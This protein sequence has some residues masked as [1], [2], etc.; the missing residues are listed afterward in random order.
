MVTQRG[1]K[2]FENR[3]MDWSIE[4]NAG[5][6]AFRPANRAF[7]RFKALEFDPQALVEL[8]PFNKLDFAAVRRNVVNAHPVAG[9][10][11]T[12]KR[13]LGAQRNSSALSRRRSSLVIQTL[14]DHRSR[15][16]QRSAFTGYDPPVRNGSN[17]PGADAILRVALAM[18]HGVVANRLAALDRVRNM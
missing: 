10:A 17:F 6:K 15:I 13:D 7:Q 9:S 1:Q 11:V 5:H 8:R 3:R 4:L 12:S 16:N 18:S 14:F 2:P